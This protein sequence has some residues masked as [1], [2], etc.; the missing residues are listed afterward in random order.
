M[1]S[2]GNQALEH[3]LLQKRQHRSAIQRRATE[4]LLVRKICSNPI[5]SLLQ[6]FSEWKQS[7]LRFARIPKGE[8]SHSQF[9]IFCLETAGVMV[10]MEKK[11]AH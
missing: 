5:H 8:E 7:L 10:G 9:T 4:R 2:L 3:F 6:L 1:S 11:S